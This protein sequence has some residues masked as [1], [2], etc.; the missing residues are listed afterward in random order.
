MNRIISD[1]R[2]EIAAAVKAVMKSLLV[3]G[4]VRREL[5]KATIGQDTTHPDAH[6]LEQ[7]AVLCLHLLNA[8]MSTPIEFLDLAVMDTADGIKEMK[9]YEIEINRL[10]DEMGVA[11]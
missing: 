6:L 2:G 10:A 7:T 5:D 9:A 1:R 8:Q 11:Q 3:F 4:R